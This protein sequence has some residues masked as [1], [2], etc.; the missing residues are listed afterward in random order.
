MTR[1]DVYL[2]SH[3]MWQCPAGP[4]WLLDVGYILHIILSSSGYSIRFA[5]Q[6]FKPAYIYPWHALAT[7]FTS[8][9]RRCKQFFMHLVPVYIYYRLF[10]TTFHYWKISFLGLILYIL[11]VYG[12][13]PEH[14]VSIWWLPWTMIDYLLRSCGYAWALT[15]CIVG[16]RDM[17][18][19]IFHLI[20]CKN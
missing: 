17:N 20:N 16:A 12:V 19:W 4:N 5:S 8:M 9:T 7:N 15:P 3:Y 2:F 1:S 10:P 13:K 6:T 14:L 18:I 11:Y